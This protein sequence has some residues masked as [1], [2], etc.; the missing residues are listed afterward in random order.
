[1]RALE[2]LQSVSLQESVGDAFPADIS[3]GECQRA[4]I[5]R[6]LACRPEILICDEVT[7]S[8][9]VSVQASIVRLLDVLRRERGVSLIFITHNLALVGSIADTV[10]VLRNGRL[11]EIGQT[12]QVLG[13]PSNPYTVELL[14]HTPSLVSE[15]T[16]GLTNAGN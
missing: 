8:L 2:L 1:M 4:A 13:K 14:E 10:A 16:K 15:M 9:D 11:I 7:S 5:A 12:S 3:G 6:A